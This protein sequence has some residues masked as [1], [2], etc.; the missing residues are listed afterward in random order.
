MAKIRGGDLGMTRSISVDNFREF[1]RTHPAILYPAFVLQTQMQEKIL[2]SKF[3]NACS[4][5]RVRL[6]SGEYISIS[7]L[8]HAHVSEKVRFCDFP[9]TSEISEIGPEIHT[10]C[11]SSKISQQ[12]GVN[13]GIPR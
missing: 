9:N 3:W 6:S 4:E 11:H 2:G 10:A 1:C 12:R 13:L 7:A 8:L 5:S